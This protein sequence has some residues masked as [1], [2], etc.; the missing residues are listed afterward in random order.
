MSTLPRTLIRRAALAASLG[1][2]L[3]AFAGRSAAPRVHADNYVRLTASTTRA[4]VGQTISFTATIPGSSPGLH[5]YAFDFGDGSDALHVD[6]T[7]ST[8]PKTSY[9][10]DSWGVYCVTVTVTDATAGG[11]DAVCINVPDTAQSAVTEYLHLSAST[12]SAAVG[13]NILFTARIENATATSHYYI[14]NFDDGS[15]NYI[16]DSS[17]SAAASVSHAYSTPGTYCVSAEV[18]DETPGIPAD[19]LC[20]SVGSGTATI[21]SP[22]SSSSSAPPLLAEVLTIQ[23]DQPAGYFGAVGD[24][25]PIDITVLYQGTGEQF[26]YSWT[27]GKGTQPPD[28]SDPSGPA[29]RIYLTYANPG[30]YTFG[31]TVTRVRDGATGHAGAPIH[32][33]NP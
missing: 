24:E 7:P 16:L 2:A 11:R 5:S 33:A 25:I 1:L 6:G 15:D 27:R 22:S 30:N 20:L 4:Q 9:R 17:F 8:S 12:P 13:Q 19:E 14:I 32:I 18:I 3:V 31:L 23:L 29:Y 28:V 10:Y 26:I 21:L